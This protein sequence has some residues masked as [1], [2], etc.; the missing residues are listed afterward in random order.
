MTQKVRGRT[1]RAKRTL[2]KG[3][4]VQVAQPSVQISADLSMKMDEN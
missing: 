3:N 2:E 1:K 4:V